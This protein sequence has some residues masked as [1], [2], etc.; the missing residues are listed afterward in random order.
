MSSEDATKYAAAYDKLKGISE[1]LQD[2][3]ENVDVD[4]LLEDV[5]EAANAFKICKDRIELA[6]RG[7]DEALKEVP[8]VE[9]SND[10]EVR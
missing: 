10:D 1:K 3:T 4:E 7:L 5:R 2:K 6:T 8:E 9:I